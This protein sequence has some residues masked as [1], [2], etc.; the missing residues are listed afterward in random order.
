[1][2]V[3]YI[4]IFCF[5]VVACGGGGGGGGG[6]S[7]PNPNSNTPSQID[8]TLTWGQSTWDNTKWE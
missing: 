1:M 8:E 6:G 2:R 7:D 4:L 3:F 5:S